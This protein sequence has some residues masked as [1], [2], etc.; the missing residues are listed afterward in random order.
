MKIEFVGNWV[1]VCGE[2]N[3]VVVI[4]GEIWVEL[5]ERCKK[6]RIYE[7]VKLLVGYVEWRYVLYGK[8]RCF[9]LI[10]NV[11]IEEVF[12]KKFLNVIVGFCGD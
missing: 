8:M 7:Y 12:R 1:E 3:N 11:K 9:S 6:M 2:V 10:K 5:N 4:V